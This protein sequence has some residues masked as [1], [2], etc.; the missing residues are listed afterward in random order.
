MDK[1]S[2]V[3]IWESKSIQIIKKKSSGAFAKVYIAKRGPRKYAVKVFNDADIKSDY[4][5]FDREDFPS[6]IAEENSMMNIQPHNN[7]IQL[8]G[9]YIDDNIV[10]FAYELG[11]KSMLGF[12]TDNPNKY[13]LQIV[14]GLKHCHDNGVVH[15]DLKLDNII[16]MDDN[17]IKIADF[18][19][20]YVTTNVYQKQPFTYNKTTLWYRSPEQLFQL[21]FSGYSDIWSLGCIIYE[22]YTDRHFCLTD[23][24]MEMVLKI[25]KIYG[26]DSI[27]EEYKKS[28]VA[29][30]KLPQFPIADCIG[31]GI[32][33]DE[34]P[35]KY[36][37]I[38]RSVLHV[39]HDCRP[40]ISDVYETYKP[41]ENS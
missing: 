26:T 8:I 9:K 13:I 35:E 16:L 29:P 30:N 40:T 11:K 41:E 37:D 25:I 27:P 12:T 6:Y 7:I 3:A 39:N 33:S 10:H 2:N 22:L 31:K 38:L 5:V 19:H 14:K 18:G 36:R 15:M 28:K 4:N 21:Y 17:T 32:D 1:N 24:E 23:N 20:S 34:I